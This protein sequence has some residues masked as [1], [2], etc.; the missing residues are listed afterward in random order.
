MNL[1]SGEIETRLEAVRSRIRRV[2]VMRAATVVV[3]VALAGLFAMMAADWF[4]APLPMALRWCMSGAWLLAVG[5]AARVGFGPVLKPIG[6]LQ[7][8]RWLETRHPEME[9]R[10][11][12]VLEL[13]HAG[14]GVS[15]DLLASLAVAAEAD[16]SKV[17]AVVEVKAARTTL[18]WGRPAAALTAILLIALAVWP[19][20]TTRLLVRA[21]APFSAVGNAAAG[22]FT[23]KPGNLEVLDGDAV[24]IEVGYDGHG[25]N[26]EL[27]MELENGQ[28]ISQGMTREGEVFRYVLNPART[29]FR[30]RV[31]AG[32]D[33][34]D[35][36]AITVRPMPKIVEPRVTLDYPEYTGV[37]PSET[38]LDRSIA[39]V[40]GTR[41]TLA[42]RTNTAVESAWL[43]VGGKRIADGVVENAANGG[44]VSIS[45]ALAAGG[46]GEAV[47]RLKHRL[48]REIEALHFSVEVLEDRA[49]EVV[50]LSPMQRDLKVRPDEVMDLKYEVTEDFAVA[51]LAVEVDAGGKPPAMLERTI[52]PRVAGSKPPRFR[53][54]E[55]VAIG[56]LRSRFPGTNELR[57]RIRAEDARP[58]GMGGPGIG[59]SEWLKLRIDDGAE[60]LARQELREEHEGARQTLEEAIRATREARERMDWHREDIKKGELNDNARKDLKEAGE[61]LASTEEKLDD[62]A[63]QMKEGVHAAKADD[64]NKAAETV[65]KAREDLEN[66]P[67]QDQP[68]ERDAKLEQARNE[69]E[70]AVK[71][72]ENVRDAMDRQREKIEDLARIQDLAQ[73]QQE[74]ARQAEANLTQ[75]PDQTPKDWQQRQKQIEEALK[76]QLRERPQ[77]KAEALKAQAAQAKALAEQAREVAKA[78]DNLEEQAK[79]VS[80]KS[81]QQALTE[82]QSKIAAEANAELSEARE[83]RN[84]VA[85]TLPEAAAAAETA[86]DEI[87]KGET[88]TAAVSAEAAAQAMK[89][90]AQK[91]SDKPAP[92]DQTAQAE[93]LEKLAGRQEQVAKAMDALAKGD[94]AEALKG[95]QAAQADAAKDLAQAMEAMPQVEGSGPMQEAKNAGKQG[96]QQAAE[97]AAQGQKNQQ[98]EASKQHD[99]SA[100]NFGKS[101]DA[102]NRAADEFAK[103]ALEAAAQQSNP[104]RAQV[105]PSAMAEAFQQA[106]QASQNP[107]AA[108]AAAQAAHAAQALTQAAQAGRQQ[109]QGRQPGQPCQPGPPGPPGSTP[110]DKPESGPRTPEADPGVPPEL[111]K[112]GISSADWEKIQTTLKSDVGA[113]EG[114]AVPEEYRELVKG[115]FESISKKSTKD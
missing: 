103:M 99:Q 110:G 105:S 86:R 87:Q 74:L 33:E 66:S 34:S 115:Y 17:D 20:A 79:Q 30:Y 22:H 38:A 40:A 71:Q 21:V 100:Q 13:A 28:K 52:P 41:V 67:L 91:E 81:L 44:R 48:G 43:E 113:G 106:A 45:W 46:S 109:M 84:E 88:Q 61:K 63:K 107:Q 5:M 95:L 37:F 8:A 53:G 65:A 47:V 14:G 101:A 32:R 78:Q 73:Q 97:A 7:V 57:L 108:E 85:D 70:S 10:L 49:P 29:S 80:E 50:L 93:A 11:S 60:S 55:V 112:L 68:P 92:L 56:E 25:K 42:G 111:A 83:A 54:D 114:G 77:A 2:Q 94:P 96:S 24:R 35:G 4:F 31:R 75:S 72:L 90:A 64:V 59:F 39:A 12:T 15:A 89:K 51:K 19:G 36:F 82:E 98:Q 3:T 58:V 1:S 23:M 27:W 26:L 102:L 16:V 62:L 69:S 9:E 6:L 76:Q 18:R 104:Q